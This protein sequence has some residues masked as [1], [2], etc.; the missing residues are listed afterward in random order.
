MLALK[1]IGLYNELEKR[2]TENSKHYVGILIHIVKDMDSFLQYIKRLFPEYPD[3]GLQHSLRILNY[4]SGILTKEVLQNMSDSEI[5]ILIMA[6][7]FHDTGMSLYE[8]DNIDNVRNKHHE[9]SGNV[10]DSYFQ[11]SLKTLDC[12]DR[13]KAVIKFACKGHGLMSAELYGTREFAKIDRINNDRVHYAVIAIL[14]RIGD[15]MDLDYQRVNP[16]VLASFGHM[17]SKESLEHNLRHLN[18]ELYDYSEEKIDIIVRADN[19]E[20]YR[21]WVKWFGYLREEILQ[22]NTELKKNDIFFRF[23][24]Q[25]LKV[26]EILRRRIYVLR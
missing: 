19:I 1:Q 23:L 17:F 7:L 20:Q 18:V 9:F 5:F 24:K 8:G 16:F 2:E 14:I 26:L 11:E 25:K 4:I 3:H 21:I 22:A 6:A 12:A 13:I 15:L 10:I